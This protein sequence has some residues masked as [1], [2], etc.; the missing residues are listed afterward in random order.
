M[1]LRPTL[2]FT[3]ALA[4]VTAPAFAGVNLTYSLNGAP[5]DVSWPSSSFP[6]RYVVE[7]NLATAVTP[8]VIDRAFNEWASIPDASL[9]FQSAGIVDGAKP[10]QDGRNSI[11]F[12]DDLFANQNFIALT[13]NWYDD[14]G[15]VKESD[16][17]LDPSA[18][19]GKY[20]VQLLIEHEIG[21]LL[22]HVSVCG[23]R[24]RDCIGQRRQD[25]HLHAVRQNRRRRYASGTGQR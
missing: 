16:I 11:T 14:N 13:T 15:K 17:Q 20:N 12:V 4:M 8:A 22:G 24:R 10:G 1:S 9:T 3:A 5:I 21:H 7:R 18:T 23:K 2:F 6:I 25:R 19:S